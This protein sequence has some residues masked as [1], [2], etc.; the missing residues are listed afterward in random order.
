MSIC[1]YLYT[2]VYRYIHPPPLLSLALGNW[3]LNFYLVERPTMVLCSVQRCFPRG[4]GSS[5]FNLTLKIN[6]KEL[7]SRLRN[8]IHLSWAPK[9]TKNLKGPTELPAYPSGKP[10]EVYYTHA[11]GQAHGEQR[12][13]GSSAKGRK[14]GLDVDYKIKL[15]SWNWTLKIFLG[16]ARRTCLR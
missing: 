5:C 14:K 1:L 12:C 3:L 13:H 11:S 10:N 16:A 6:N 9:H 8:P 7:L 2:N 15:C 4:P